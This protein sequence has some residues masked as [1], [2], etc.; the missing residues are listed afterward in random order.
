MFTVSDKDKTE[1]HLRKAFEA[2]I[3]VQSHDL[4]G[5]ICQEYYPESF[6]PYLSTLFEKY[7]IKYTYSHVENDLICITYLEYYYRDVQEDKSLYMAYEKEKGELQY[8]KNNYGSN[9]VRRSIIPNDIE[10]Y[11]E[12]IGKALLYTYICFSSQNTNIV[13]SI[14]RDTLG[15]YDKIVQL[16]SDN[17]ISYFV[18]KEDAYLY[19]HN[20]FSSYRVMC[21][22][23]KCNVPIIL[24]TDRNAQFY[25]RNEIR[26]EGKYHFSYR[27]DIKIA[28]RSAWE[29]NIARVLKY[30]D[31]PFEYERESFERHSV[32]KK[33]ITGY[34]FPDFF[35]PNNMILEVKG[36]W[37]TDSRTKALEFIKYYTNYKYYIIDSDMYF[38]I[39]HKYQPLIS[40]WEA[41]KVSI[42]LQQLQAVGLSKL[43]FSTLSVGQ[44]VLLYRDAKNNFDENAIEIYTMKMQK[45]GFL[46]ADWACIYAQKIDVGMTFDATIAKIEPK[47]ITLN[48]IR[49]NEDIDLMFDLFK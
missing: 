27:P 35:L 29:A 25:Y 22:L 17:S 13:M 41:D 30:L 28:P 12:L 3:T 42:K 4:W 49:N 18:I 6:F 15:R 24:I 33:S 8:S 20:N 47:V 2:V 34:Y 38:S 23:V 40:E 19:K 14:L 36:F 10:N 26:D 1:D 45:I 32:S 11:P 9:S 21:Q 5:S 39:K 46:S 44:K 16:P 43:I 48:V 31:I 37:N 7:N